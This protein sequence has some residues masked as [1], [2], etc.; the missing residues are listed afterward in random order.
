MLTASCQTVC[1]RV[2]VC[3]CAC[4][5]ILLKGHD[6]PRQVCVVGWRRS[7]LSCF[8][9]ACEL[10]ITFAFT[11]HLNLFT[12]HFG[13]KAC[14]RVQPALHFSYSPLQAGLWVGRLPAPVWRARADD[15]FR[16]RLRASGGAM[17][18]KLLAP[19]DVEI[20]ADGLDRVHGDP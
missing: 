6:T 14:V 4:V 16:R 15:G 1:V 12:C 20:Q 5:W 19:A 3:V 18:P 9:I 13:L 10:C 17:P 11:N 2:C 7:S 8:K